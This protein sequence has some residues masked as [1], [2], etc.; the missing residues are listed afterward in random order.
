MNSAGELTRAEDELFFLA[1]VAANDVL[2][3]TATTVSH[4]SSH[5]TKINA[6]GP[7]PWTRRP[8][9]QAL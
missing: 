5:E 3:L 8:S 1:L 7:P 2:F 4:Y 6:I 9:R